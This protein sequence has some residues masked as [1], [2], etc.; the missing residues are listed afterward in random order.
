MGKHIEPALGAASFS[1]PHCGAIAQQTWWRLF[2]SEFPKKWRLQVVKPS[3]FGA[4]TSTKIND[5]D[6]GDDDEEA[7]QR[8]VRSRKA[9]KKTPPNLHGT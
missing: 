2:L 6:E 4:K 7:R 5:E 8:N 1:C 9:I 3:V